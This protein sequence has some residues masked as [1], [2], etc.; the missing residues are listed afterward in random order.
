MESPASAGELESPASA[1]EI[2]LLQR[3]TPAWAGVG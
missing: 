3:K 2:V 1:A